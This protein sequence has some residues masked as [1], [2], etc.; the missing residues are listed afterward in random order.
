MDVSDCA[1]TAAVTDKATTAVV[2]TN[3]VLIS[4][5]LL[6]QAERARLMTKC[7]DGVEIFRGIFSLSIDITRGGGTPGAA[8]RRGVTGDLRASAL[9]RAKEEVR[10]LAVPLGKPSRGSA[11]FAFID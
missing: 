8:R 7:Q 9:I 10:A 4:F 1:P 6:E 2:N 3:F 5:P 11:T